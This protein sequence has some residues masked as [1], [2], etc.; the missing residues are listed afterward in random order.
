M[1]AKKEK[2]KTKADKIVRHLQVMG[3]QM[4]TDRTVAMKLGVAHTYVKKVRKERWKEIDHCDPE[5]GKPVTEKGFYFSKGIKERGRNINKDAIVEKIPRVYADAPEGVNLS[6]VGYNLGLPSK[7]NKIPKEGT[8]TRS[9]VLNTAKQYVT[10]DRDATH[11]NMEDNFREIAELWTQYTGH[12]LHSSDVAVMMALLKIARLKSNKDN[13]DNWV[14]ACGY[15]AC[16][17]ELA[18]KKVKKK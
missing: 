10:K 8:Y 3:N 6:D 2:K 14:D 13:P 16:G 17:G 9:S 11:G 12:T 7:R 18:A 1:T 5:L 15:L 4:E